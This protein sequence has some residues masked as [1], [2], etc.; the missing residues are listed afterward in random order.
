M[1]FVDI[2]E[3][4]E[5]LIQWFKEGYKSKDHWMVGTEHEKFAYTFSKKKKNIYLYLI[6]VL[7]VLVHF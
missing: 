6:L 2:I 5:Q 4:K 3:D 1:N 7:M